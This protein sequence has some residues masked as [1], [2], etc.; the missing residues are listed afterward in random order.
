LLAED[1][2]LNQQVA[3]GI[4]HELG[5]SVEIANNGREA[6]EMFGKRRYDLVFMDI[7]MP[8]MNGYEATRQILEVQ[9]HSTLRI[10]IIAMTAHAMSGDREKCLAAGMDDYISKPIS[11]DQ[12]SLVIERNSDSGNGNSPDKP[13][14][15]A[16]PASTEPAP[17]PV[18]PAA[19]GIEINLDLILSRFGGNRALLEQVAAMFAPESESLL[20]RIDK[21]RREN[22]FAELESSAHS[23]KGMCRMFEVEEA[24][25]LVFEVETAGR[26]GRTISEAQAE[27][28]KSEIQRASAAISRLVE[29]KTLAKNAGN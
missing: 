29:S 14:D 18:A 26:E 13:G 2:P 4:L 16:Q 22:Q 11:M 19:P 28:L 10:P 6:V 7:Q 25:R 23:L 17:P 8:E 3:R 1:N 12:L 21:A 9:L 24:A 5:H 15:P 27:S 20:T